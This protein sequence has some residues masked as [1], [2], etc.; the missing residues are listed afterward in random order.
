MIEITSTA[1]NTKDGKGWVIDGHT[2]IKSKRGHMA[3]EMAGVFVAL[4]R[5]DKDAFVEAMDMFMESTK[6]D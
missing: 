5:A 6:N 2:S 4:W 3:A 1:R